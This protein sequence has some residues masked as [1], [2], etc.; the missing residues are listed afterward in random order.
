MSNLPGKEAPIQPSI[1]GQVKAIHSQQT[2]GNVY[3]AS[4]S[5]PSKDSNGIHYTQIVIPGDLL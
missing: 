1:V 3:T 5:D 2:L 4:N